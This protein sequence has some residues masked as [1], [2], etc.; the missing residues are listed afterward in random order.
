MYNLHQITVWK[1]RK[2]LPRNNFHKLNKVSKTLERF[3][4]STLQ[5]FIANLCITLHCWCIWCKHKVFL[6]R[7][8]LSI[9]RLNFNISWF[10]YKIIAFE[11]SAFGTVLFR[12]TYGFIKF[13]NWKWNRIQLLVFFAM[14]ISNWNVVVIYKKDKRISNQTEHCKRLFRQSEKWVTKG[15]SYY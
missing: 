10:Q 4:F 8:H 15:R 3:I 6:I 12:C 14:N 5:I 11:Q 7:L 9:Y 2:H 1:C 13:I